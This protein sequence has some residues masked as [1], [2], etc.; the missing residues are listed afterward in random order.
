VPAATAAAG[1]SSI[2]PAAAVVAEGPIAAWQTSTLPAVEGRHVA[3]AV[4]RRRREFA[5]GRTHARSALAELGYPRCAIPAGPRREPL[6]PA[7]VVGSITHTATHCAAA[8]ALSSDLAALG[9]DIEDDE[10]LDSAVADLIAACGDWGGWAPRLLFSAKESVFKALFPR[11]RLSIGFRDVSIV[12]GPEPGTFRAQGAGAG[13]H[14]PAGVDVELARLHGAMAA[15]G[16][17]LMT[18]AWIPAR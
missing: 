13:A 12:R 10:P 1:L 14:P 8:V 15:A 5:A 2:L 7:G 11:L 4:P 3:G 6:W 16:G 9:I 17:R 18:A